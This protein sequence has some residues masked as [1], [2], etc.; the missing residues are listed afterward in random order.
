MFPDGAS[1]IYTSQNTPS[2]LPLLVHSTLGIT[3]LLKRQPLKH[4]VIDRDKIVVAPNWDSWGKIR[5]LGGTF[6]AEAISKG[7]EE[8]IKLPLG[9]DPGATNADDDEESP[10]PTRDASAIAQY[11]KWCR[12]PNSGGLA[13]VESAMSD[14]PAV[15]VESENPQEFL[16]RQ[17]KILEAFKAKAPEKTGNTN[18][19]LPTSRV[20]EFPEEKSVNDHIGPVQFNM[21][22]IQVDADD[23]LQ[24]L[25]VSCLGPKRNC[26]VDKSHAN[27]WQDRNAHTVPDEEEEQDDIPVGNFDNEQLQSFFSGLMNRTAGAADSPRS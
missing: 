24:R 17:L 13:V 22:G 6:D 10:T 23:M 26:H 20:M 27:A 15:G 14:G 21:G 12:D 2:Q 7:W 4:N 19:A 1:L 11:E 8:D 16:E 3:S 18:T 5:I 9:S 25:K